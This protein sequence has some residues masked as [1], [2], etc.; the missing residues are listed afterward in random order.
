MQLSLDFT[1]RPA[2]GPN[3]RRLVMKDLRAQLEQMGIRW[4]Y[5]TATAGNTLFR[6]LFGPHFGYQPMCGFHSCQAIDFERL[7]YFERDPFRSTPE[8]R[9]EVQ[10]FLG[11]RIHDIEALW[12]KPTGRLKGD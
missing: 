10:A 9:Q 1:Q 8:H 2:R 7:T 12:G 4:H 6:P 3:K 5:R 11:S